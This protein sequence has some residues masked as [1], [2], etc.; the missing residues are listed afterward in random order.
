MKILADVC[1]YTKKHTV[2]VLDGKKVLSEMNVLI[3]DVVPSI[4][5]YISNYPEIDEVLLMGGQAIAQKYK[6]ELAVTTEF[7]KNDLKITIL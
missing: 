3:N 4:R 7:E 5:S 1:T 6:D 2:A